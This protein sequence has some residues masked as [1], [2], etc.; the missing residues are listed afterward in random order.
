[1][2]RLSPVFERRAIAFLPVQK[3]RSHL[4]KID[5]VTAIAPI[6]LSKTAISFL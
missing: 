1:M 3:L 5:L 6:P 2:R 4:C